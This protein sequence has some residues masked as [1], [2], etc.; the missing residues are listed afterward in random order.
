[1]VGRAYFVDIESSR[2]LWWPRPHGSTVELA[3]ASHM[4]AQ[5][6]SSEHE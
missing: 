2:W 1:M 6:W 5:V 3:F 4:K